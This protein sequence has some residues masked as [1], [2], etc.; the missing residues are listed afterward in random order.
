MASGALPRSHAGR[1]R[2]WSR[3][4]GRSGGTSGE[5]AA[6]KPGAGGAAAA[7]PLGLGARRWADAARHAETRPLDC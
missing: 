3:I 6:S 5:P 4:T 1:P 7:P 2:R